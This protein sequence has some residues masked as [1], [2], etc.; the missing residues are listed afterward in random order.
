MTQVTID[1]RAISVT[2][3]NSSFTVPAGDV[4]RV[5]LTTGDDFATDQSLSINGEQVV[6]IGDRSNSDGKAANFSESVETVIVG[7]D[8]VDGTGHIGGFDVS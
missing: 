1:N 8:T 4:L 6:S 7:G 2:L 5:T 3:N